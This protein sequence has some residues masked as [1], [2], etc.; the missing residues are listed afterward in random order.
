MNY[1]NEGLGCDTVTVGISFSIEKLMPI[2]TK[3][4]KKKKNLTAYASYDIATFKVT[5][6]ES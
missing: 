5:E 1:T 3:T 2:M 6:F 4:I